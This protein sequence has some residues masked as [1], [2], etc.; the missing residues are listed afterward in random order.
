M[1]FLDIDNIHDL[2]MYL[3]EIFDIY[4]IQDFQ[5][6]HIFLNMQYI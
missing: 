1:P 2:Q 6:H 4:S 5:T 3:D